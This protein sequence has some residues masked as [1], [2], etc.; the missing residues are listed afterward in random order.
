MI[1]LQFT[2]KKA[3]LTGAFINRFAIG[4]VIGATNLKYPGWFNG[5]LWGILL[6]LPDAIITKAFVPIIAMGAIGGVIIGVVVGK[7]G[8]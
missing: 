8:M 5:L 3:A 2:D 1:P 7:W 4:L 6:S